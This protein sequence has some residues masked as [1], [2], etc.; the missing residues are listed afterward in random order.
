MRT[1]LS[2]DDNIAV[3]LERLRKTRNVS[4]KQL[5]NEALRRGL[6]EIRRWTLVFEI[7]I[8]PVDIQSSR[9]QPRLRQRDGDL[10]PIYR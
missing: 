1:T 4:L 7:P 8:F 6:Q 2:I 10:R 3:V 9:S 5:V